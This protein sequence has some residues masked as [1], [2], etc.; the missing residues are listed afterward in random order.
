MYF[1]TDS[2]VCVCVCVSLMWVKVMDKGIRRGEIERW[3]ELSPDDW[4]ASAVTSSIL[5]TWLIH[6]I[7]MRR[8]RQP[9]TS[10]KFRLMRPPKVTDHL[11]PS[12]PVCVALAFL[13]FFFKHNPV[14]P[15]SEKKCKGWNWLKGNIHIHYTTTWLIL[16]GGICT[17]YC[18]GSAPKLLCWPSGTVD[19]TNTRPL[20]Q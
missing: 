12:V 1:L 13:F 11:S 8:L 15:S 2:V 14:Q 19:V 16:Q 6:G 20:Q 10:M 5:I 17:S 3:Q 18:P 9:V 7:F 4:I